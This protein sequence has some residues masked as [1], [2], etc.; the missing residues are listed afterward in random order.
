MIVVLLVT[1]YSSKVSPETNLEFFSFLRDRGFKQKIS[2]FSILF[3]Y[4]L[5]FLIIA[6][7]INVKWEVVYYNRDYLFI[8]QVKN[9][10]IENSFLK[11]FY[12][13]FSIFGI[14]SFLLFSILITI[15]YRFFA[16]IALLF[17]SFFL[18]FQL[19]INSRASAMIIL[20]AVPLLIIS[21]KKSSIFLGIL[22]LFIAVSL[23]NCAIFGRVQATQGFSKILDNL[24]GGNIGNESSFVFIFFNLFSG[25]INLSTA[26]NLES[27]YP[28]EYKILSFSPFLSEIDGFSKLLIF[29]NRVNSFI[30]YGTY[31]EI[32][33]FGF[34]FWSIA[35]IIIVIAMLIANKDIIKYGV[36]GYLIWLPAY[37]F[38]FAAQQYPVRSYLRF[39]FISLIISIIY[40][41]NNRRK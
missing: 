4:F 24:Y 35:I 28:V 20:A 33:H 37:L 12:K 36:I 32:Y 8:N 26:I 30:P 6:F 18:L 34:V 40:N 21:K 22:F 16:S 25:V 31:A 17:G 27:F 15:R 9:L 11:F 13:T 2:Y 38:I 1:I 19:S 39:I 29:E 14:I 5:F 41:Y 3:F 23:Y 10:G 7:S